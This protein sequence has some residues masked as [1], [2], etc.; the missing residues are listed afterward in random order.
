MYKRQQLDWS[1]GFVAEARLAWLDFPWHR[2]YPQIDEPAVALRKFNAE[3]AYRDGNYLGNFQG[4]LDGPAGAFSLGSP[5]SGDLGQVHLPQLQLTAGQGKAQGHLNLQ[6]ADGLAWDTALDLSAINPA[7]WLAELPGT[8]AGPLRSQGELKNQQ[9]K[10]AADLDLKG[11]LRGQP[12]LLQAKADGAGEQWRL[13]TLD[14][15]PVS[16]THLTLPTILRV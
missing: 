13:N 5:F 4:D 2:L 10:L 3:V 12:A 14:I 9:L 7:Y 1:Q 8:L 15:R 16:Y 6:F 11:R